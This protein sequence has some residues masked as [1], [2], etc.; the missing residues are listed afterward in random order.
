MEDVVDRMR[1]DV[2]F[3][4]IGDSSAFHVR[5]RY[6]DAEQA[7]RTEQEVINRLM[8]ANVTMRGASARPR[9]DLTGADR[10]LPDRGYN[11]EVLGPASLPKHPSWPNRLLIAAMGLAAGLLLGAVTAAVARTR[12]STDPAGNSPKSS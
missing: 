1:H 7:R 12:A 2:S 10:R 5:F 4:R 9:P 3:E 8:A 11:M 6:G